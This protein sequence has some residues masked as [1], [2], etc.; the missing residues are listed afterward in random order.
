VFQSDFVL[1]FS[2]LVPELAV[3]V[4]VEAVLEGLL[5][6]LLELVPLGER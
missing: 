3:A 1:V 4:S 5:F 6:D 2:E